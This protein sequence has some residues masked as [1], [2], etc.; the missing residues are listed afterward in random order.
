MF[1][2]Y[3]FLRKTWIIILLNNWVCPQD[4]RQNKNNCS[5]KSLLIWKH[6]MQYAVLHYRCFSLDFYGFNRAF[7]IWRCL[8]GSAIHNFRKKLSI[9]DSNKFINKIIDRHPRLPQYHTNKLID[10]NVSTF[11][12]KGRNRLQIVWSTD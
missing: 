4:L 6:N 2:L 10:P 9:T 1:S 3:A 7:S 11:K 12:A 5:D 8:V